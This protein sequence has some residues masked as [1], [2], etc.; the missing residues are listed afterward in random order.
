[1]PNQYSIATRPHRFF[2]KVKFTDTCWLWTGS[3]NMKGYGC[4]LGRQSH[5][6]AYEFCVGPIPDGLEIDHLCRT[7][8]CQNPDHMEAVTHTVNIQRGAACIT[9]CIHGHEYTAENTYHNPRDGG[10]V[11]RI[12][13]QLRRHKS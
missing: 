6:W 5:R 8:N 2:A 3:T 10:R 1:M 13:K 7:R 11:C 12:C 4:F 9:H